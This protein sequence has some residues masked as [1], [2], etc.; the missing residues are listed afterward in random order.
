MSSSLMKRI[1]ATLLTAVI[2]FMLASI[3]YK[4]LQQREDWL[5]NSI[6]LSICWAF[7]YF[8]AKSIVTMPDKGIGYSLIVDLV[9]IFVVLFVVTFILCVVISL[10][11]WKEI[12]GKTVAPFGISLIINNKWI[13]D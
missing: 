3:C 13:R 6:L 7:G 8:V 11:T 10:P 5:L 12:L 2:I 1:G 9:I 4:L